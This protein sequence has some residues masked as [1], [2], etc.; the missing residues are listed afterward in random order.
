MP[1]EDQFWGDR[2]GAVIDPSGYI[3]WI[4]T[5]KEEVTPAEI[6]RRAADFFKQT[7]QMSSR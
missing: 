5:H 3:W 6:E 4:A 7:P 1:L 2:A